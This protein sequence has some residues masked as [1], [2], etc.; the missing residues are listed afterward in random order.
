MPSTEPQCVLD[1]RLF[2]AVHGSLR[3][4]HPSVRPRTLVDTVSRHPDAVRLPWPHG[5]LSWSD[6]GHRDASGLSPVVYT[7]TA[8]VLFIYILCLPFPIP[9]LCVRFHHS[10]VATVSGSPRRDVVLYYP[11]PTSVRYI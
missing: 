7:S 2:Y 4:F 1:E 5:V 8:V 9:Y 11:W 3:L 6:V 10:P